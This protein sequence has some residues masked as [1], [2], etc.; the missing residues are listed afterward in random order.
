MGV[1]VPSTEQWDSGAVAPSPDGV[2]GGQGSGTGTAA[3]YGA[4]L[5][6]DRWRAGHHQHRRYLWTARGRFR[7][8][9]AGDGRFGGSPPT[10]RPRR[11]TPAATGRAV[12]TDQ[13][14]VEDVVDAVALDE[15]GH[16]GGLDLDVVAA[17]GAVWPPGRRGRRGWGRAGRGCWP[18][19]R[20]RRASR[21]ARVVA[22]A[23]LNLAD[24][25]VVLPFV[26]AL[27]QRGCSDVHGSAEAPRVVGVEQ[28][29]EPGHAPLQVGPHR[30]G[31][32]ATG[33]VTAR[34]RRRPAGRP[35]RPWRA[36]AQPRWHAQAASRLG[37]RRRR[38]TAGRPTARPGRIEWQVLLMLAQAA[39]RA[40][41]TKQYELVCKAEIS[42]FARRGT[43]GVR[44]P[45]APVASVGKSPEPPALPTAVG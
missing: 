3:A 29:R 17:G 35:D 23:A 27:V 22:W 41:V 14:Q 19:R 40:P 39:D 16:L 6:L 32:V 44:G 24:G 12:N 42:P 7:P 9:L 33:A 20:T 31:W 1:C 10:A 25:M 34:R 5:G 18:G 36:A 43:S 38:A 11:S 8:W 2:V 21:L 45:A 30:I 28:V 26:L 37:L 4:P 15:L 13:Q